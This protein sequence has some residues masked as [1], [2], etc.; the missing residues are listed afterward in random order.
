MRLIGLTRLNGSGV[1]IM[2]E[3]ELER[4]IHQAAQEGAKVALKEIGLSDNHAYDDVKELR[5]LLETWKATKQTIGTTVT[6][7]ITTAILTALALGIYM[8]WGT[9]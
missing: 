2:T 3:T 8:G 4:I 1:D 7:T 6:R 9:E 5:S